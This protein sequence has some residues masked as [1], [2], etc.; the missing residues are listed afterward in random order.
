MNK[1][2]TFTIL[3]IIVFS[4]FVTH[5]TTEPEKVPPAN[6]PFISKPNVSVTCP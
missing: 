6:T 3:A 2:I 4:W 5:Y 1:I